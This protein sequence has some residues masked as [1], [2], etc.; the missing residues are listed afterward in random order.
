MKSLIL[1]WSTSSEGLSDHLRQ[2]LTMKLSHPIEIDLDAFLYEGKFD[3]VLIGA[4]KDWLSENFI[5]PDGY[6]LDA[7][8]SASIWTFGNIEFHFGGAR[9]IRI[10]SDSGASLDG[11]R[12]LRVSKGLLSRDPAVRLA[13]AVAEILRKRVDFRTHHLEATGQVVLR[14]ERSGVELCF[15]TGLDDDLEVGEGPMLSA[16]YLSEDPTPQT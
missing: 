8:A 2:N 3:H 14:V 11:G 5:D 4:T 12:G 13:E 6:D 16:F 1:A 9:L 15:G 7:A 10:F